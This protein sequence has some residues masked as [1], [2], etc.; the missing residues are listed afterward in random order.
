M[1]L[2]ESVFD[3]L[4]NFALNAIRK[5]D[6]YTNVGESLAE[7]RDYMNEYGTVVREDH[8]L[9][10]LADDGET[11]NHLTF[12]LVLGS[13]FLSPEGGFIIFITVGQLT[14]RLPLRYKLHYVLSGS[15]LALMM[16]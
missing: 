11:K 8:F 4:R 7:L 13:D 1:A 6:A 16:C 14:R 5:S 15:R 12:Y 9:D 2:L 3:R 10:Y